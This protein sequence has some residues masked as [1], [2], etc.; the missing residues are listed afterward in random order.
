MRRTARV[1]RE[2]HSVCGRRESSREVAETGEVNSSSIENK[3]T[4]E[5]TELEGLCALA[6]WSIH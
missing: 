3:G 5:G 2:Y 1:K 6:D 4:A